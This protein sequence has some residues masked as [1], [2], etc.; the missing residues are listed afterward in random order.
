MTRHLLQ[1]W[2]KFSANNYTIV[3]GAF[4]APKRILNEDK[5]TRTH[6]ECVLVLI[7]NHRFELANPD[8][9]SDIDQVGVFDVRV[10]RQQAVNCRSKFIS[11]NPQRITS[12]DCI[13]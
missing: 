5:K 13:R 3:T 4:L 6:E 2:C 7:H 9:L 12:L 1:P 8:D 10:E 11:N